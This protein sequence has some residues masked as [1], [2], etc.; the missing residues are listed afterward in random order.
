MHKE[1][2]D[3]LMRSETSSFNTTPANWSAVFSLALGVTSLVAA[4]FIPISLLTPMARDLGITEGTAGQSVTVVGVFAVLTSLLLSPL[5]RG[6]N[7]RRILLTFS[8]LL[9]GSNVLVAL[10]PNF[11]MLLV[12]R[13][14]LGICVGGFWSMA[15]AVT[16]Q[17]APSK[18]V[19]RALGFIYAGVSVATIISLP[20]ASF[21]GHL[22]GWRNVFHLEA[23]LGAAGLA[24][25]YK[26][27][28][29]LETRD[30]SGF[31][32]MAALLGKSWVSMGILGTICSFGGYHVF[33]TYLRPFLQLDLSLPP[34]AL[35]FVLGAYGAANCLGTFCAAPILGQQFRKS[36]FMLPLVLAGVA[37]ALYAAK[38]NPVPSVGLAILW[39][40][41]YGIIPVGWSTWITRTLADKAEV[42]GGLSVAAI[43]FSIGSAA[44]IGGVVFDN[45]GMDGIFLTAALL[46]V[47]AA[48]AV[49][50]SFASFAKE[51]GRAA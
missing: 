46:L 1:G 20:L 3:P 11:W 18:D 41:I 37:A 14:L 24:W 27:L 23:L 48:L 47:L 44:A 35:A 50:V 34:S 31:R 49:A 13:G 33:F 7:R 28:P 10:A 36:M 38:G 16:L 25:Q 19:P 42:A 12:A 4:E 5:T 17:L 6:I 8:F 15:A 21:L 51:V 26:A 40:L 29:P 22:L 45:R 2:A 39:G 32:D 43:Q 9:V 30:S